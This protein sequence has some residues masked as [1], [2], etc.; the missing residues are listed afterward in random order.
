M[1]RKN[2]VTLMRVQENIR[3]AAHPELNG[4]GQNKILRGD[5]PNS[6]VG[7]RQGAAADRVSQDLATGADAGPLDDFGADRL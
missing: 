3:D 1:V 7:A 6:D 2:Q 4:C 5:G